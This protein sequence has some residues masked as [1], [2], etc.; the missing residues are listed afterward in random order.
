MLKKT[1]YILFLICCFLLS[2]SNDLDE[3]KKV[4]H[5]ANPNQEFGKDVVI[6]YSEQGNLRAKLMAP[7]LVRY[8]VIKPR[9]EM[10][11]GLT[12]Q[13]FGET[14]K[15]ENTLTAKYGLVNDG[16]QLMT[17]KD[18]VNV[19]NIKG[20]RLETEELIWNQQT[21]KI[22]SNA[23]VKITTA[24]EIIYGEGMEAD[25]QFSVYTLKKVRGTVQIKS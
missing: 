17:A 3:A 8:T 25:E 13:V 15:I 4:A 19:V 2:C 6:L 14:N 18:S 5:K 1:N 7:L 12:L 9:T 23:F 10:T 22:Y 21:K 11:E 24:K 16:E 20:E